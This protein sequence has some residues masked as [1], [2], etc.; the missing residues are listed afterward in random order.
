MP[1]NFSKTE[2]ELWSASLPRTKSTGHLPGGLTLQRVGSAS[3][4]QVRMRR[5]AIFSIIPAAETEDREM[6]VLSCWADAKVIESRRE[7]IEFPA[8]W[9][10][11]ISTG[12]DN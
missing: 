2:Q 12:R 1:W 5:D 10:I 11:I 9:F 3:L 8:Q 7:A 6:L 4:I